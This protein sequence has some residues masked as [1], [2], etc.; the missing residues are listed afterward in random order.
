MP[1]PVATFRATVAAAALLW[2]T[3][4]PAQSLATGTVKG[5][6]K[7]SLGLPIG[8]AQ[9]RLVI[10]Q[11]GNTP[12]VES[13]DNGTFTA[14]KVP[15]GSVW[16][17]ARRIGY[18]PDSVLVAVV[19]EQQ[20][21]ATVQLER[22]AV[23]L[24]TVRVLGRRDVVGHLAGFYR[25]MGYGN[26]RF[27]TAA[28]L[29]R[30]NAV[31][32]TDVFRMIPGLR[33]ETRGFQNS[34]RMRGSRCAP[35]VWLDGQPLYA[36]EIDLDAFDPKS[37][38]GIEVYSGAASVPVE[39]QGNQRMS[40]ACGTII[41]WSKRGELR[42][43]KRKKDEPTPAARIA[44]LLE[45]GK[46]YIVNDVDAS[47]KPDSFNLIR[48]IYPDSLFEAQTPGRVLAE[49]VVSPSGEAIMD[50]F[51][52]VTTTNRLFV[53]PVRRAVREQ[54]FTPATKQGKMVQQVMQLPFEF[55][56]DST[57]RRRK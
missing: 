26:G 55:V 34:V 47:A 37:F 49:F 42:E 16:L 1:R 52:A 9:M 27:F 32:M 38:D 7:S 35:L 43:R 14:A 39:F 30:R 15:V 57:A 36:G 22:I 25:R 13:D 41:L 2:G 46:A 18:R 29:E 11:G 3:A 54:R 6:V 50:T 8:G 40:S 19:A 48:P 12:V 45:T 23:E 24:S 51:S 21:E 5:V 10:P 4:L 44:E 17:V 20:V 33:I 53:E 28:D 31:H 56:P